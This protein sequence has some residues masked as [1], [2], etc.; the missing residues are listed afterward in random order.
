M[1]NTLVRSWPTWRASAWLRGSYFWY[2]AAVG[3]LMPY[4]AVYYRSLDLTGV[5]IGMLAATLPL[6][7]A[8]L[9][10]PL[11]ALADTWC[12]HR[13]VLRSALVLAALTALGM[14]QVTSFPVLLLLMGLLA[15]SLA[16]IPALLDGYAMFL[17]ERDGGSYGQMR[18]WGTL[19]FLAGVWFVGWQMRQQ[20]SPFFLFAYV[21]ALVFTCGA[22][23][24]LPALPARPPEPMWQS[25]S[26]VLQDRSVTLVLLTSVLVIGNATMMGS[27]FSL[28]LTELGGTVQLVGTASVLAAL[29][30]VP[31]MVGGRWLIDR[32]GSRTI[33]VVAV[34]MY[35]IRLGL[36]SLPPAVGW[37]VWVQVLHGG[38]F[39]LYLMASVMLVH[40]RAGRERAATAQGLLTS[41]SQGF[42]A[43]T[44]VL[45]GGAL[46]DQL[47]AVGIMRVATVGMLLTLGICLI[48]VRAVAV[49]HVGVKPVLRPALTRKP[50]RL[51]ARRTHHATTRDG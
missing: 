24:G 51:A 41:A 14:T 2:L 4:L 37:V 26:G 8:V 1:F 40:E 15:T 6:G 33:L 29:S 7:V 43:I 13:L 34:V 35:G 27:Y 19:G 16:A 25:V 50:H 45:I 20:V 42:G 46:L 10:P 38:S 23:W 47:G 39:G 49:P 11:G 22:T 32:V 12:A 21:A 44:G 28:Y 18:V 31:V 48:T 5:Q 9:A 17:S 30:E 36:Y 3:C